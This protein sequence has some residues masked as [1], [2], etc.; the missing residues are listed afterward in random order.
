[1]AV[2]A[3][4]AFELGPNGALLTDEQGNIV[5]YLVG[6]LVDPVGIDAPQGTVYFQTQE[7]QIFLKVGPDDNDWSLRTD[8]GLATVVTSHEIREN[9]QMTV[10]GLRVQGDG[11]LK[12]SGTLRISG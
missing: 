8:H 2:I 11:N 4:D 12:V 7:R 9:E 3:D 5:G 6:G 1:M 10:S